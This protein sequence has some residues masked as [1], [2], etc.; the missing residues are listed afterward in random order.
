MV[1]IVTGMYC[2]Q[3]IEVSGLLANE[4]SGFSHK[5]VGKETDVPVIDFLLF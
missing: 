1:E 3:Q 2:R 4:L 5:A